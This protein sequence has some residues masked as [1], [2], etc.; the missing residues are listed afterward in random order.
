MPPQ[1][2]RF[3]PVLVAVISQ[4][5]VLALQLRDLRQQDTVR[6]NDLIQRCITNPRHHAAAFRALRSATQTLWAP[7]QGTHRQK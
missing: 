2:V 4:V 5:P 1:T 6:V 3:I 7:S